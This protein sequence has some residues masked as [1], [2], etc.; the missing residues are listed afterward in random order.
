MTAG[1]MRDFTSYARSVAERQGDPVGF[2]LFG[3]DFPCIPALPAQALL[4][5]MTSGSSGEG[6][7]LLQ[8]LNTALTA[9]AQARFDEL[10][11]RGDADGNV[12]DLLTLGEIVEHLV[13]VYTARPTVRPSSSPA[14][15]SDT[16]TSSRVVSLAPATRAS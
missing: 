6:A 3:Q 12:I 15:S 1:Q 4:D 8:L 11:R 5:F 7:A 16:G 2:R 9:E 13:E 14:S 10:Y